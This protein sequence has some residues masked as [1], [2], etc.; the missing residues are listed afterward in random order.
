[1]T[2]WLLAPVK[3]FAEAKSRLAAVLTRAERALLM[4]SLLER[5]LALAQASSLFDSVLV[6]SR[7]PRVWEVARRG[8]AYVLPEQGEDLNSALAQGRHFAAGA[9]VEQLLI[10]PADLPWLSV[11]DLQAVCTL[12]EQGDGI[13]LGPAEDGGTNVFPLCLPS[14]LPFC[15]GENSFAYHMNAARAAGLTPAVYTSATLQFDL[16]TPADWATLVSGVQHV[17]Q[18][19]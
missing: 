17:V 6:V 18:Q 3:P 1:M 14:D 19:F 13:V 9:G 8:G 11:A 2:R 7:D 5:T 15:F 16:D 4:Q 10:L 12:G